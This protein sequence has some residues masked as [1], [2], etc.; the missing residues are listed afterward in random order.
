MLATKTVRGA[1]WLMSSRLTGRL[2]D[3]ATVIILARI[4]SPA[5]FGL[6]ALAA[7]LMAILDTALEIPLSQAL[8]RLKVIDKRHLDTAFTLGLC[9]G[10]ALSLILCAAAWPFALA[11]RDPRLAPLV[12][13]FAIGP[14]ARSLYSPAMV[15]YVRQISFRQAFAAEMT[16]RTL[17]AAT[18]MSL[19]FL[20]AGYWAIVAN[21]AVASLVTSALSYVIA[22]YRPALSFARFA[23][24]RAFLGWF[25]SAQLVAAASW[26]VDRGV[27]GYFVSKAALGRYTMASDLAVLPTQSLIGP[28]MAPVMAAFSRIQDDRERL[29]RA[30]LRAANVTMMIA[31]PTGLGISITADLIVRVMLG[32]QWTDTIFY[33]RWLAIATLLS[34]AYQPL[35]SVALAMN[36]P[37]VVFRLSLVEITFKALLVALGF[38]AFAMAGVVAARCLV[39]LGMFGVIVLTVRSML[40]VSALS[41][42]A[43]LWRVALSC[44]AMAV[45]VLLFRQQTAHW[46]LPAPVELG[47]AAAFGVAVYAGALF[48]L[49]VRPHA[50]GLGRL[51]PPARGEVGN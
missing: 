15:Q 22:P 12:C 11:F 6:T 2:I 27:L 25:S 23:D 40:G 32:P 44:A 35:Y 20:G 48:A 9:R 26:Q 43:N 1:S 31:V 34:A 13:A 10:A 39:S 5:D 46:G 29:A 38:Y 7:S 16:G 4:L 30:Y 45:L 19:A 47:A 3:F 49:G 17:A 36:R 24:F 51:A 21:N 8:T 28:A 42:L 18:A 41:Q 50:I 37:T 33:L 14:V